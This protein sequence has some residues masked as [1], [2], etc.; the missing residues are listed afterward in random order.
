MPPVDGLLKFIS[1]ISF[2]NTA[3]HPESGQRFSVPFTDKTKSQ[4]TT[5]ENI[6]LELRKDLDEVMKG[7]YGKKATELRTTTMR[8]CW[9]GI[10]PDNNWFICPHPRCTSLFVATAGSFHGW[11]FLPIVGEYVVQMLQGT[12]SE[13][14]IQRW[15]WDRPLYSHPDPDRP[16]RE[17][18]DIEAICTTKL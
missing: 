7:L 1:D 15:S 3:L 17:W 16:D 6:P 14:M 10:T 12:L 8:I 11:K 9:D 4:W 5:P 13:E 2:K 18:R